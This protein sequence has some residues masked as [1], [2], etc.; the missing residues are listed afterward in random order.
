MKYVV[1][2]LFLGLNIMNAKIIAHIPEA[3]GICY[4]KDSKTLVVVNDEGTIYE[5]TRKGKI[6]RKHFLGDYD[7]EG[8]T[9]YKGNLLL[10]VEDLHAV[11]VVDARSFKILKK[12]KIKKHKNI[13]KS[14]KHGIE[15]ISVFE[16][17]IYLSHQ[18][19]GLFKINGIHKKKAKVTKVYKDKYSDLS[20]L[21]FHDG[22]LY[23][24]SD[25]KN[26][27]I[28]YDVKNKRTIKNYKTQKSSPRGN[29]F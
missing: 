11:F 15:G 9:T 2:I 5:L 12:V 13:E 4:L 22:Y 29:L 14:K 6:L 7:L 21:S 8:V 17:D 23:M 10:A 25:K 28:K 19:S 3:S 20:G 26:L 18:A 16:G 1:F 24:L 27:L